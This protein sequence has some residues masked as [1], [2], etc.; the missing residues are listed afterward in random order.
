LEMRDRSWYVDEWFNQLREHGVAFCIADTE[1]GTDPLEVTAPFV[2]LRL[3]GSEGQYTSSYSDDELE[4]WADRI[5]AMAKK[6]YAVFCFFAN[7]H[8]GYAV[9][10]ARTLKKMLHIS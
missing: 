4:L 10:N 5:R 6:A 3:H 7:D 9:Q 2:Y 1:H 8:H